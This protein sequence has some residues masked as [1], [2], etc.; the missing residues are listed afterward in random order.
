[1][2]TASWLTY[3]T[4]NSI[5][6]REISWRLGADLPEDEAKVV[7]PSLQEFQIG[8]DSEGRRLRDAAVAWAFRHDDA[9]FPRVVDCF[10]AEEQ[11]HAGELARF[12]ALN[13]QGVLR[14]NG[15]ERVFR[16]LRHLTGTL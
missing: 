5:A 9:E 2:S 15:A 14:R 6:P 10:I 1:M 12:L 3:F 8:E 7:I 11:R 16:L 13:G 4:L